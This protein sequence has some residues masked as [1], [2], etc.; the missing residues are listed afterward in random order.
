MLAV[1]RA[2]NFR[3]EMRG[4]ALCARIVVPNTRGKEVEL[5]LKRIRAPQ[6]LLL[7]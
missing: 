3:C 7:E 6:R 4:P 5:A 1:G 2:A